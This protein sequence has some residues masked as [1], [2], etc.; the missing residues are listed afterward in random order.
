MPIYFKTLEYS[1]LDHQF[2]LGEYILDLHKEYITMG[3]IGMQSQ[4]WCKH[5]INH[6]SIRSSSN[7]SWI[8]A[9]KSNDTVGTKQW[10]ILS[11]F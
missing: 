7:N 2:V 3:M 9:L 5:A 10:C 6:S 4:V 11:N 8:Y 1:S